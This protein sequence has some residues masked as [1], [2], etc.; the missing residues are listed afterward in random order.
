MASRRSA[1]IAQL[2]KG[3]AQDA[4]DEARRSADAAEQSASEA[5]RANDFAERPDVTIETS[6]AVDIVGALGLAFRTTTGLDSMRIIKTHTTI[7]GREMTSGSCRATF[8]AQSRAVTV[9]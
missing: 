8:T 6:E 1:N 3:V 7:D 5:K 2:A 9:A 4:V